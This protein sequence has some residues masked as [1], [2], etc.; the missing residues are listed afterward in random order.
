MDL[1]QR[2]SISTEAEECGVPERNLTAESARDVP[3]AGET[4]PQ[5]SENHRI[6]QKEVVGRQRHAHSDSEQH[7]DC[8]VLLCARRCFCPHRAHRPNSSAP[9]CPSKPA[10]RTSSTT[11]KTMK[12]STS[13]HAVPTKKP[14]ITSMNAT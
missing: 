1:E 5:Q 9:R 6:L 7:S 3:G 10:G 13:F 12:Y 4:C 14:P 8:D 11:M 2:R